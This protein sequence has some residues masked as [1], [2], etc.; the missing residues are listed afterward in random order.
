MRLDSIKGRLQ[1]M[2]IFLSED[3]LC[4]RP[5]VIGYEKRFRWAWFATQMNTFVV[6]VDYGDETV[7]RHSIETTL[8]EAFEY[9]RMNYN[10][11]PRGFQCGVGAIAILLSSSVDADAAKYCRELTAG[12]KWAGFVVP[13]AVDTES[14]AVFVFDRNPVWGRIYYPHFKKIVEQVVR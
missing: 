2:G 11:W 7:S 10:G 1:S 4:G 13:V 3:S 8:T 14:N 9:A 6:A 5:T 12:K